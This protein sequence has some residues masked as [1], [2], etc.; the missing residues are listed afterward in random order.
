MPDDLP[1]EN[2]SPQSNPPLEYEETPIIEPIPEN[3]NPEFQHVQPQPA[4]PQKKSPGFLSTIILIII[5]LMAGTGLA[6]FFKQFLPSGISLNKL[7]P[8][9]P[10]T[11]TPVPIATPTSA[12]DIYANWETHYVLNGFTRQPI[13]GISFKL[14]PDIA[15]P[16]CDGGSCASQGA[17]LPGGTRFTLAP[18]GSGQLLPNYSGQTLTDLSGQAFTSQT[19]S[20]SGLPA[21]D[22]SGLFVGTTNG[23]Y[24][25]S[26]MHGLMIQINPTLTLEV[27]HFTPNGVTA[28]FRSDDDLFTKIIGSFTFPSVTP[29]FMP[30]P[31]PY[32]TPSQNY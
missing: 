18:R 11:P 14:P 22:F 5:L 20:I 24:A 21:T 12:A 19:A 32:P 4:A 29:T 31:T 1:V 3:V 26:Q 28:D 13:A 27:S 8:S 9:T 15:A 16:I 2:S 17:Y 30:T 25:F 10:V 6:F 23:G 7:A